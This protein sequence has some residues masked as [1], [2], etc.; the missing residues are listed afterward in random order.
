MHQPHVRRTNLITLILAAV[1]TAAPAQADQRD[2]LI[3]ELNAKIAALQEENA[4]LRA[5]LAGETGAEQTPAP[6]SP[7]SA[8]LTMMQRELDAAREKTQRLEAEMVELEKLAGVSAKGELIESAISL[9][10]TTHDEQADTTTVRARP[11]RVISTNVAGFSEYRLGGSFTIPAP[12]RQANPGDRA[13]LPG[14]YQ[15]ELYTYG[16]PNR[17]LKSAKSATLRIDGQDFDAPVAEYA[18]IDELK[19][20]PSAGRTKTTAGVLARDERVAF[21]LSPELA[22]RLGRAQTLALLLPKAEFELGREHIAMV[23]AMRIRAQKLA[24]DAG[25]AAE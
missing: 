7:A 3:A 13:S 21:T 20:P 19:A 8:D 22:E 18:V 24:D 10:E 14:A 2:D 12:A 6:P 17:W 1:L 11:K 15:L 25:A 16:N 23:E 9:F 5:R 4:E